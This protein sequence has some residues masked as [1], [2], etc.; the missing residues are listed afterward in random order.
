VLPRGDRGPQ[1]MDRTTCSHRGGAARSSPG[2]C[3]PP[4]SGQPKARPGR[5]PTHP[6]GLIA[7]G[8]ARPYRNEQHGKPAPRPYGSRSRP[9]V[10]GRPATVAGGPRANTPACCGGREPALDFARPSTARAGLRPSAVLSGVVVQGR[11]GYG[12]DRPANHHDRAT[13]RGIVEEKGRDRPSRREESAEDQLGHPR[14]RRP[15]FPRRR[16]CAGGVGA[17][18]NAKGGST[19]STDGRRPW[20]RWDAPPNFAVG[21]VPRCGGT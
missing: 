18:T 17:T 20:P 8:H 3:R 12:P 13:S 7:R 9:P 21:G 2:K 16:N 10:T 19:T 15:S 6:G 1:A 14:L 4:W 5:A 11:T